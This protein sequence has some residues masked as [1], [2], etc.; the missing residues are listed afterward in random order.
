VGPC[1][2]DI[3]RSQVADGGDGLYIGRVEANILNKQSRTAWGLGEGLTTPDRKNQL[4]TKC[5]RGPHVVGSCERGNEPSGS[6]KGGE[7]LN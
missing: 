5:Y 1:H 7:F 4:V 3:T 2:H 6:I